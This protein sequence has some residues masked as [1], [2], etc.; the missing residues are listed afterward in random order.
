M[1]PAFEEPELHAGPGAERDEAE[2]ERQ[3]AEVGRDHGGG[4]ETIFSIRERADVLEIRDGCDGARDGGETQKED[5]ALEQPRGR[6]HFRAH[7]GRVE[8]TRSA[9]AVAPLP[10]PP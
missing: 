5:T 7:P 3:R 8:L 1:Q 6:M 10:P 2:H 9:E 4:P